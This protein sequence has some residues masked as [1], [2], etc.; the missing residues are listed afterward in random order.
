MTKHADEAPE[1][2]VNPTD[3]AIVGMAIRCPGAANLTEYWNN[4][5][6]GVESIS[7][8]SP[9][10]LE[11]SAFFPV[12][13]D[14]PDFVP[15]AGIVPDLDMF[16]ADFF[17]ISRAEAEVM[18]PQHRLFLECAWE[19]ME[20]S[21]HDLTSYDGNVAI[22]AGTASNTYAISMMPR[23][24]SRLRSYQGLV[25]NDKD[26]VATRVSYKLNLSGEAIT[27]QTACSTSLVAVHL[28]CQSILTGQ[29]DVAM[30]GGVSLQAYQKTGYIYADDAIFSPDGHCRAFDK[31]AAGSVFSNG[32]GLV[33]LK[34]L[35]D[36][37]RDNDRI[38]AVIRGSFVNNDA[39]AKVSYTAPSVDAQAAVIAGALDF[40]DVPADSIGYVETHGTGTVLGDPIEIAALT[41]AFRQST[42]RKQYCAIGSVKTNIGHLNTVAGVA[43]LIKTALVLHHKKIPAS[44]NFE[45]PNP[46]IPF[47]DS[48]FYVNTRLR[49][50]ESRGG[51]RRAGVSA[52]GI[53]GTNAHVVL[54]EAPPRPGRPEIRRTAHL[55]TVSARSEAA[56]R[57]LAGRH[58]DELAG[59]TEESMADYCFTA[60]T[61]RP[62]L[63]HRLAV[64][65]A[66]VPELR[67][68]LRCY[69][70][71]EALSAGASAG[72]AR[73]RPSV[74]FQFT[75]HTAPYSGMGFALYQTH[76]AFRD[77]L[78]ECQEHLR[79]YLDRPLLDYLDPHGG[80]A[81]ELRDVRIAQPAFFAVEYA[82]AQQWLAWGVRPDAVIGHSL[83]EYVAACVA[84]VFGPA[85]GLRLAAER[86]RLLGR[87]ADQGLMLSVSAPEDEV[88]AAVARHQDRVSLAAV[89]GPDRVVISG[90][91][92]EVA[93]IGAEFEA[94]GIR[95][96]A[97]DMP[98]PFHSPLVEPMLPE[99]R[100]VVESVRY[101]DPRIPLVSGRTGELVGPAA[102]PGPAYWLEHLR[103][104]VRF[105]AGLATLA[106][107]GCEI[108]LEVG[109]RPTLSRLGPRAVPDA[110]LAWVPS[111][112]PEVEDPRAILAAAGT[113]H[114]HG[115]PVDWQAVEE[116][117]GR[118][119][120]LPS[121]PFQRQRYWL[122]EA[123]P[124]AAP[125]PV[126]SAPRRS[127]AGGDLG[128]REIAQRLRADVAQLLRS[129]PEAV[130]PEAMLLEA[131]LDSLAMIEVAQV[132]RETY[133]VRLTV[134]QLMSDLPTLNAISSFVARHRQTTDAA[135]TPQPT[136]PAAPAVDADTEPAPFMPYRPITV[137]DAE[138]DPEHRRQMAEFVEAY[139][140]RTAGS[141]RLAAQHRPTLADNDN[142]VL[143]DFRMSIKEM[144]YPIAAERSRGA[145]LWDVDGN[146]YIDVVMGYGVNLFGHSPDFVTA[147]ITRQLDRGVHVGAQSPLAGQ[148]ATLLCESTGMDRVA[149]CN[150][151]S[152]AVM[153]ALRLAR[154][155]TGRSTVA[156]FMGSYHGVFDGT[157]GARR[158]LR[159][160][161]PAAPVAPGVLQ[162]MVDD[163][164]VLDYDDPRSLEIIAE[165]GNDLAAVLVEPVQSRRPDVQPGDFLQRLRRLTAASGTALIFDEV[166]TGFRSHPGGAQAWF[167]VHADLATYGKVIGGGLPIGAVAG[168]RRFLDAIDGGAWRYG[169]DSFPAADTTFFA[170]TFCKHPLA[171]ASAHAVLTELARRGPALQEDLN[172][173]TA[174]MAGRLNE[175]FD[176]EN[177]PIRAVHFSSLFRFTSPHDVHLLYHHLVHR[178][179]HIREGHNAFLSA[180]HTDADVDRIVLA[181][182][183]SLAAL[184]SLDRL[185]SPSPTPRSFPVTSGQRPL[186]TLA[187][188]DEEGSAAYHQTSVLRLTGPVDVAAL[189]RALRRVVERHEAL[190]TVFDPDG[191]TQRVLPHIDLDLRVTEQPTAEGTELLDRIATEERR[192]FD[193]TRGPLLR[194]A[195]LRRAETSHLLVLTSHHIVA[196]GWSL[197]L[198]FEDICGEYAAACGSPS[199][200]SAARAR[201]VT[202]RA[203]ARWLE[204]AI[205]DPRHEEYWRGRLSGPIPVL[206]LPTDHPRPALRGFR[207]ARHTVTVE[208]ELLAQVRETSARSGATPFMLLLAAYQALLHRLTGQEDL[209]VG[210][211]VGGR[212]MAGSER[213]V[214]HCTNVLPIRAGLDGRLPF[215]DLLG[216]CRDGLLD[217]YEHQDLPL[218]VL[219]ERLGLTLDPARPLLVEAVF[220]LDRPAVVGGLPGLE[221]EQVA[222]PLTHV[223]FDLALNA[224]ES[225]GRLLL[226]FDYRTDLFDAGT[227]EWWSRHYVNLLR[228][229]VAHPKTRLTDLALLTGPQREMVLREWNATTL[230]GTDDRSLPELFAEQV[231][232][233][234]DAV[235]VSHGGTRLTY[236]EADRRANQLAHCLRAR[237][238]RTD[239]V[240]AIA[241]G[242][243]IAA[244]IGILGILKAGCAYLPLDP[245][246]PAPR[247]V[248]TIDDSRARL[249]LAEERHVHLVATGAAS[250][251]VLDAGWVALT[252]L[253]EAPLPVAT[254]PDNAAYVMYTSGSQ[255]RRKGVVGTHRAVVN[256]LRWMWDAYPFVSGEVAC[257]RV[258][259]TFVDS[260]WELFGPLLRGVPI[261]ILDDE[262][263]SDAARLIRELR[264]KRV[265]RIVVVP[266][267]LRVV[268]T[269]LAGAGEALPHLRTWTV[270]GE[271]LSRDLETRFRQQ[272]PHARLLNLYGSTEVA[273]DA[274]W[275]DT[276]AAAVSARPS[277]TVPIGRPITGMRVHLLDRSGNLAPV[278]VPGEIVVGGPGLARG[279]LHDPARTAERFVPDPFAAQPGAR[280]YRTGD[281]A[282]YRA[283]GTLEFLGRADLQVKVGGV[284]VEPTEVEAVL[285][286]HPRVRAAAVVAVT[287]TGGEQRLVA[288]VVPT[289]DG[290]DGIDGGV[291][292]RFLGER[293]PAPLVPSEFVTAAALPLTSSGKIARGELAAA[294]RPRTETA[295]RPRTQTERRLHDLWAQALERAT[296]PMDASLFDLGGTSLTAMRV[297]LGI[298][299]A[300]GVE[301]RVRELFTAPTVTDMAAL[302][303]ERVGAPLE[304]VPRRED[305]G[306]APV[307]FAQQ[308]L[309]FLQQYQPDSAA[310]NLPYALRFHGPL[311]IAALERGLSQAVARHDILR[312]TFQVSDG[313]PVQ[314]VADPGPVSLPVDDLGDVAAAERFAE[315]MRRVHA[316]A[317]RP[318]DL[319]AG[320]ALRLRLLRLAPD[321]HVLAVVMHHV[322]S[323][324]W[325]LGILVDEIARGYRQDQAAPDAIPVQYADYAVWQR[326]FLTDERLAD[327]LRYWRDQLAGAPALLELPTD[328][329]RSPG[330]AAPVGTCPVAL[331]RELSDAVREVARGER[332]TVFMVLL[333]AFSAVLGRYAGQDDVCVGTPVANRERPETEAL[334]GFFANTLV[335]RSRLSPGLTYRGLLH[336][337]RRTT[338]T[339]LDHQSVPF[340]RLVEELRPDRDLSY[341]P[342]FQ[343]MLILHDAPVVRSSL[344]GVATTPLAISNGTAKYDVSLE[345]TDTPDGL[346][347][348]LE[349]DA[350]LF[351]TALMEGL[352]AHLLTLLQAVVADPDRPVADVDLLSPAERQRIL[353]DWNDTGTGTGTGSVETPQDTVPALI[354]RQAEATPERIAARCLDQEISYGELNRRASRLARGLRERGVGREDIVAVL[355][356]RN[357]DYL[358]VLLGVL[359]SGAAYLPIDPRQPTSRM[360]EVV[361]RSRCVLV[362]AEARHLDALA[363]ALASGPHPPV[364]SLAEAVGDSAREAG[365]EADVTECRPEGLAY[366]LY[367][368][369]ST[370]VPK[371][372]M[373]EHQGMLN[374]ALAKIADLGITDADVV[375]QNGP[376]SFDVSVWQFLAALTVG[377][378]TEILPEEIADDPTRLLT[379]VERRSVTVLQVV[380]SMLRG[381]VDESGHLGAERPAL[382]ALRRLVP[383]GDALMA[384]LAR[385]WLTLFPHVPLLNTYGATEC[386]DDQCHIAITAAEELAG[387]PPIVS[388]GR[389]IANMR[390]YVLDHRL[391]PVPVGVA[392]ELYL[393]G[394]GVGRGYLHDPGRTAETFLPDPFSAVPGARLYRTKDQVRFHADGSIEFLGRADNLIKVRGF[395]VEPGEIEAA[396]ERHPAVRESVVIA[397][398]DDHGEARLV[399]YVVADQTTSDGGDAGESESRILP[400][401]LVRFLRERLPDYLVPSV[402]VPM[403]GFPLNAN[404]KVDRGALPDAT[405]APATRPFVE[406]RTGMERAVADIWTEVLG[407]DR[408]GADDR[409]FDLGGHSLLATRVMS[410]I[411]QALG[412]EMPLRTMFETD[413]VAGLATEIERRL[414][415]DSS[416]DA[417]LAAM[418]A[419]VEDLSDEAV[420][421]MLRERGMA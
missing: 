41:Q 71:G 150:S 32:L 403:D 3:I 146:E 111:L 364:L 179:I 196:D 328:R 123:A 270:S 144:L 330:Q 255:G 24:G 78:D 392:G 219:V 14:H 131:G 418:V 125:P 60:H 298:Q 43:G 384:G 366:V 287:S 38:Y 110:V 347:G 76:G 47:D 266:S 256:R 84:G 351:D 87:I 257:Q 97:L 278:G 249:V 308:R 115:A 231:A 205:A 34:R 85:D 406:P 382:T 280:L 268:L 73:E 349:Y 415:Q 291:L 272:L 371:G 140:A 368:S 246:H 138:V 59:H 53:G 9:Q 252:G 4:L 171:M 21:G 318:F 307:S 81:E 408:V 405:A 94:R 91:R 301:I 238:V 399:G 229:A 215:A 107:R 92:E 387:S 22:Y 413:S 113:L 187:S 241:A 128:E 417:E 381:L 36:A 218:S 159:P 122:D 180:A 243:S 68:A 189:R 386:S 361:R 119:V 400:D 281:L 228:D 346:T 234:P 289:A 30:A 230:P 201:P 254:A 40:A 153:T 45:E 380:P 188:L 26:Y 35:T 363:Q 337:V 320:P 1:V 214:G 156:M 193:L 317:S 167:G 341:T 27:V 11:P 365:D 136:A 175:L 292:R 397:R 339:A 269:A 10:E 33:V 186:L 227:I 258:A 210:V 103:E 198:L 379:E 51:P 412:V 224:V 46:D 226:N 62:H 217:A 28:A 23:V 101:D 116:G 161:A 327:G 181:V 29:S 199:G 106:R 300:C 165:L 390:A 372:V 401:E 344:R 369:G 331:P 194:A 72:L 209:I 66:S 293:L 354:A 121:Y 195:L 314:A 376:Q 127:V 80:A 250:V 334:V 367:T 245:S 192:P 151:G 133:G 182:R 52:F 350:G 223:Q 206:Q 237:G 163:L 118:R 12:D 95:V 98:T 377:G 208:P 56:L 109:P 353:L 88:A 295:P 148:V 152:E 336:E 221:V 236:R 17:G 239:D 112:D 358:V 83:G 345:L 126:A 286:R 310:M 89:N 57:E 264:D 61:G 16:D 93:R 303:D 396:L 235:C 108:F 216:R 321:E 294:R 225:E 274:T 204:R 362:L 207:G 419:A 200:D 155:A 54:E 42:E 273:A 135:P 132:I 316:E 105:A 145:R 279:Y 158:Q 184:R 398:R 378:R 374:H 242:R 65:A 170:G 5:V 213:M 309:W 416:G 247:L 70:E 322:V 114:V 248:G 395:R 276:G 261:V 50:F 102:P 79:T 99:F 360:S 352:A 44:L 290:G 296:V 302:V 304:P 251:V 96:R 283:D 169:D 129:T 288:H 178:G 141:K 139:C 356:D 375:A 297:A 342:L 306:P 174:T 48:P 411:R 190:R 6:G 315:A 7:F 67:Q 313:Q 265:T 355:A 183:E 86:G 164:L 69:R 348:L 220:N 157:L 333:A 332:A 394:V 211:P 240:V 385:A 305:S 18:D 271:P 90:G 137:D 149:F 260:V 160:E 147:A 244:L 335:L 389:P 410:R 37:V 259:G 166:I 420:A 253:D 343:A 383:T 357:I 319:A 74:A 407:V 55:L 404:G 340:E 117:P 338:L 233:T 388:I 130:D 104:P 185:P 142:R 232:R 202:F 324:G 277:A 2:H 8:F 124:V 285:S 409:F 82:L 393:S 326:E 39:S 134:R 176:D 191:G 203:Y 311:D 58:H 20:D 373:V 262:V 49:D 275:Y 323:D 19:A 154:A 282:R 267:L 77:A 391:A 402:L 120:T 197:G 359:K 212:T 143:S 15:A 329:Q 263:T 100:E 31:S 172:Q 325:S 75:G 312:T 421:R 63:P 64:T 13:P 284:R 414:A 299:E 162:H 25:G 370:G 168:S 177:V 173:K 222:L